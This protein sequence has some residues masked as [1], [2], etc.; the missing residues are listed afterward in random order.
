MRD[1]ITLNVSLGIKASYSVLFTEP[2]GTERLYP[3]ELVIDL[4]YP[5]E[6]SWLPAMLAKGTV[7]GTCEFVKVPLSVPL[8]MALVNGHNLMKIK[9]NERSYSWL[10]V[11]SS[12][13]THLLS[14]HG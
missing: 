10:Q 13:V 6:M 3:T 4:N 5:V 8:H 14:R 9:I 1:S 2:L 12:V 7:A 11:Y